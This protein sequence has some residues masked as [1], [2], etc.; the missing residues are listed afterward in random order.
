MIR[1]YYYELKKY[2]SVRLKI[3][4]YIKNLKE[5]NRLN[6]TYIYIY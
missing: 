6:M 5:E 3:N 4:D 2:Q 1:L